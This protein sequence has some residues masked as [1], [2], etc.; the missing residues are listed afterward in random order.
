MSNNPDTKQRAY[1]LGKFGNLNAS[2]TATLGIAPHKPL[3]ILSVMDLIGTEQPAP[4]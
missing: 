1:W 2:K 4:D 3:M